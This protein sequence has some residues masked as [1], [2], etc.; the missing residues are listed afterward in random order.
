MCGIAGQLFHKDE[1]PFFDVLGSMAMLYCGPDDEGSVAAKKGWIQVGSV[2]KCLKEHL[3]GHVHSI[4]L[5]H[6]LWFRLVAIGLQSSSNEIR[7]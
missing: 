3:R 5:W 6:E 7:S 4:R 2:H 1:I